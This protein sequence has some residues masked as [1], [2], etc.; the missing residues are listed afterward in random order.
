MIRRACLAHLVIAKGVRAL[1]HLVIA[2]PQGIVAASTL[3]A[4]PLAPEGLDSASARAAVGGDKTAARG[5]GVGVIDRVGGVVAGL[6]TGYG[7]LGVRVAG[8]LGTELVVHHVVDLPAAWGDVVVM[9]VVVH[10]HADVC[11]SGDRG[12]GMN[13]GSIVSR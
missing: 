3:A 11:G 5:A 6:A 13:L 7:R 4:P 8:R 9:E 10:A 2:P 1:L 12:M